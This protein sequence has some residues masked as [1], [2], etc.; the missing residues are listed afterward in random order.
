MTDEK[1][2]FVDREKELEKLLKAWDDAKAGK[3]RIALIGGEIGIGKTALVEEFIKKA[4]E[5]SV[6]I[7][8]LRTRCMEDSIPYWPFKEL[9]DD[10]LSKRPDAK[11]LEKSEDLPLSIAIIY[12]QSEENKKKEDSKYAKG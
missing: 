5:G 3:S 2:D 8:I 11:E 1:H 10:Y 9:F 4:K 7:V 6:E 12:G